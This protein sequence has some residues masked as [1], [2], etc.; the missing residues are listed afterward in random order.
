[1]T[2]ACVSP[3]N[4]VQGPERHARRPPDAR[5]QRKRRCHHDDPRKKFQRTAKFSTVLGVVSVND[6]VGSRRQGQDEP[7][8]AH[9]APR[10]AEEEQR[11][12]SSP[13]LVEEGVDGVGH[14]G[15]RS[16]LREEAIYEKCLQEEDERYDNGGK[17]DEVPRWKVA[18]GSEDGK[19]PPGVD[20][21]HGEA[22]G[23][24]DVVLGQLARTPEWLFYFKWKQSHYKRFCNDDG[25]DS[26]MMKGRE[27]WPVHRLVLS[28]L[29]PT[30]VCEW[31]RPR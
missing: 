9:D 11:G 25:Y 2:P 3:Q 15:A 10:D 19:R 30:Y 13:G 28:T 7:V 16:R 26:R 12:A 18:V 21:G 14:C 5:K 29:L 22:G 6:G 24:K 27:L 17:A 20:N 4:A 31:V 1:M 8:D 23:E